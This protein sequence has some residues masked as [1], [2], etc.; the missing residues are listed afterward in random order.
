M[1][2]NEREIHVYLVL[3]STRS[4]VLARKN[5][6]VM[7]WN[8]FLDHEYSFFNAIGSRLIALK[9]SKNQI[10]GNFVPCPLKAHQGSA[11]DPK[12]QL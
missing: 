4:G 5:S 7:N 2:A 1:K 12:L 10:L 3:H 9:I 6:W 8:S 11:P